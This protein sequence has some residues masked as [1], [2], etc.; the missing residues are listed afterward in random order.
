MNATF[1]ASAAEF[2]RWLEQHHSTASELVLGFYKKASG[3]TGLSYL[4][5]V[6][7]ALCFGWIDGVRRSLDENRY[8]GRFSPRKARSNWSLIN[9]RHV[10]RLTKLGRMHPAGLAAYAARTAARTGVYSFEN[11]PREFPASL[12]QRFRANK[13]AWTFW[14]RQPPGYR[15]TAIWWVISAKQE[16]TRVRRLA[17]L[18]AD[19]AAGQRLE[20]LTSSSKKRNK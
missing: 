6:D 7:E 11:R 12:A 15:R 14:E 13:T 18:I 2:R 3:K 17:H 8:T 1:F 10:E 9:I 5:A 20:A 19:S 16:S 4:E